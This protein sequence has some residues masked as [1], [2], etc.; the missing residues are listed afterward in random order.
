MN[1]L[2]EQ[3]ILDCNHVFMETD[4]GFICRFCDLFTM[5]PRIFQLLDW[6]TLP[7]PEED[8]LDL[9]ENDCT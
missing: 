2:P 4:E 3:R 6:F 8:E 1:E 5:D 7:N 9:L